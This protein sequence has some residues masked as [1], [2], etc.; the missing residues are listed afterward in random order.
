ML[1]HRDWLDTTEA[2]TQLLQT[3]V[4]ITL[5]DS[6]VVTLHLETG[7]LI[8]DSGHAVRVESGMCLLEVDQRLLAALEAVTIGFDLAVK[9]GDG[10]R[11]GSRVVLCNLVDELTLQ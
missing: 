9:K 2:V 4:S 1:K 10:V 6:Q 7:Y 3:E 8:D 5:C 11:V